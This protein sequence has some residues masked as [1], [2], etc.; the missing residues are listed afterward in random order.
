VVDRLPAIVQESHPPE[1][2]DRAMAILELVET[3]NALAVIRPRGGTHQWLT[4]IIE[5]I[6]RSGADDVLRKR[7]K[8]QRR[9]RRSDEPS[10]PG[11]P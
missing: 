3:Q 1:A 10:E 11:T 6:V 9:G 2:V 4:R 8:R 5:G 7:P